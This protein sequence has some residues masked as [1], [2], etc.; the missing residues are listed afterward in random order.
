MSFPP[1]KGPLNALLAPVV[2][3]LLV[4]VTGLGN[5]GIWQPAEL[6]VADAA[7]G[8][9]QT[10][11]LVGNR[12]PAQLAMVRVGFGSFGANESGGRMPTALLAAV[13][14]IAL[15]LAVWAASDARTASFV[16]IAYT[17]MP[18]VF[19][20]A[21]Q[22]FGGGVAQSAFTL[23]FAGAIV[24]LYCRPPPEDKP[25]LVSL[26]RMRA[27]P[28]LFAALFAVQAGGA[29]LGVVPVLVGV[30]IVPLLRWKDEPAPSRT[31]GLV[32]ASVGAVLALMAARAAV[33]IPLE[34]YS[35]LVGVGS[36]VRPPNVLP[37]HDT[38]IEHIGH[39]VFP[40]TG[41]VAFGLAR[42]AAAPPMDAS[43]IGREG[44]VV[45]VD[46]AWRETGLRLGAIGAA[47]VAFGFQGFHYQ[48]F[49]ASPFVAAAPLAVAAGIALRDSERSAIGWKIVT[50]GVTFFTVIM[51]RD[52][53]LFPKSSYAAL[54]LPDG[55]PAFPDGFRWSQDNQPNK[56][57][58]QW[59][60]VN[61]GAALTHIFKGSAPGEAYFV[62]LGALYMLL[63]L[64]PLFQGTG[65]LKYFSLGR[66]YTWMLEVEAANQKEREEIAAAGRWRWWHNFTGTGFL[67]AFR[68]WAA[69][70]T[71]M[72]FV[73]FGGTAATSRTLGT[74][75]KGVLAGFAALPIAVFAGVYLFIF[76][77]N[78]FAWIGQ[79]SREWFTRTV[80]SR[81]GIVALAGVVVA[82]AFT[83]L[84]V[85]ALSEH[86]SP[87][88]VLA[89][90]KQMRR[91][92]E[93]VARYGGSSENPG[94]GYYADFPVTQIEGESEAV[95][96]LRSG[97]ASDRRYMLVDSRVFSR[98]NRGYRLA[99]PQGSRRN[100]P[101]LDASNSN[102]YV[103]ASDAGERGSRSPLDEIVMSTD[104]LL[105]RN[106]HWHAHGRYEGT[107]FQEEPARFDDNL[108][109][110]GYNLDSKGMSYVPVGGSFKIKYHFRV[111]REMAGSWQIFVH[112]DGQC[113]RIN[114][115]HEPAGGRYAVSNWLP[116]DII[117]DEQEITIP[118][119]CR[120]GTYYVYIGFFQGDDRM[121]V[122]GGEH[123]RENRVVAARIVVR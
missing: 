121:R 48:Q 82:L 22:M 77:W 16:G 29:M 31:T 75:A 53:L 65:T 76:A 34:N 69:A 13:S 92:H 33:K 90:I 123:D 52:Y 61:K 103:A 3:A 39:A 11:E 62:L 89:V 111:L 93:R 120:S 100:I 96:W 42:L 57:I 63:A 28:V 17:T 102:L 74:Q 47:V 54:G 1:S 14:A 118:G 30:G 7:R 94:A 95:E 115:D 36:D 51:V 20:N 37:T 116:G 56:T 24:A 26:Y 40:W 55:G 84:Y 15:A 18:L 45:S 101:V 44:S 122:S 98:L 64:P 25:A 114:G 12:P 91:P 81:A 66:P 8:A 107:R 5:F 119:Y 86:L 80:G 83:K 67:A 106:D 73:V 41:L 9:S 4:I 68:A 88:G 87:R 19:M 110:L 104:R 71:L 108:E 113:P 59:F 2:V 35:W 23:L 10:N 6:R 79:P 32:L 112:I 85:P 46:D 21:R 43:D 60:T 49:G 105:T 50:A 109:F 99:Q 27:L 117:H 70:I 78:A 38:L 58:F 72:L 97:T